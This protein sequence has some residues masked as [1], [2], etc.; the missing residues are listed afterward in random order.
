MKKVA[1]SEQ[2]GR[3]FL[4]RNEADMRLLL[5]FLCQFSRYYAMISFG[6][7]C[8]ENT[9]IADIPPPTM[10]VAVPVYY[11]PSMITITDEEI[12]HNV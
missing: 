11:F 7:R 5:F 6:C 8:C 3:A 12:C 10:P 9:L 1:I 4:F 2:N